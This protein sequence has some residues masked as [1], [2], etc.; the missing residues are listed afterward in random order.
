MAKQGLEERELAL[1]RTILREARER[2]AQYANGDPKLAFALRRYV[3]KNLSYDERGTPAQ[4][5]QL[6]LMKLSDQGGKCAYESCPVP[7]KA[8][9]KEDEPEL[10]RFDPVKGYTAENTRLVHHACHRRS[11]LDKRFA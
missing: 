3:Y 7:G 11:Q 1:A 10:D 8:I 5:A 6:K 9:T 2:V 4:R